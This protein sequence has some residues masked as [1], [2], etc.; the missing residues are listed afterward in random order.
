MFR[1][2]VAIRHVDVGFDPSNVL[3]MSVNLPERRYDTP[4]RSAAYY[5]TALERLRA[6]PGVQSAGAIDSL[7][8]QGGSFQPVVV[9][10]K[11]E[12]ASRDQPSV[13]IREVTPGYLNTLRIPVIRGRDVVAG[14]TDVLLVSR[15]AAKVLW[16][17][18]DPVGHAATL[19][20]QSKTLSKRVVGIVGD[21]KQGDLT[22]PVVPTIY[23]YSQH[24][25]W[26]G[27]SL[28][29]RTTLPSTSI[30]QPV[31]AALKAIDV[32][33]PIEDVRTMQDILDET[34]SSQRFSTLLLS[35]F[36]GVALALASVG[37]YSVLSYI[38]RGRSREIGIRTALGATAGD[39]LRLVVLEGMTPAILGIVCGAIGALAASRA[40]ATLVFGI[41]ASDPLTLAAVSVVL[42]VVALAASLGPAY[43]AARLD[44]LQVL[45]GE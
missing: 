24:H 35:L 16:G 26:G 37:I 34:L 20:L 43:R 40:L 10:G 42:A 17:D 8:S 21:V 4:A 19:P 12:L 5:A 39:V 11:A 29:I 38:V 13:A 41:S 33:Q 32:E 6:L 27:L 9:D 28:A 18:V 1:S 45:R 22:G 7:P 15:A 25:S 14:D 2:L 31:L 23:Q 30:V 3:T 36:A 44:P